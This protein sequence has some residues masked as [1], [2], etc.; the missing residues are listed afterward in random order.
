MFATILARIQ[1][2]TEPAIRWISSP[3][4]S[5]GFNPLQTKLFVLGCSL[6]FF[7]QVVAPDIDE[8]TRL[9]DQVQEI[10]SDLQL[11]ELSNEQLTEWNRLLDEDAYFQLIQYRKLTGYR[12]HGEFTLD[13]FL[14]TR[15]PQS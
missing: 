1:A 4:K 15:T 12:Q 7:H 8:M 9:Q 3:L 10:R 6:I 13:E 2:F 5:L 11:Q 14:R